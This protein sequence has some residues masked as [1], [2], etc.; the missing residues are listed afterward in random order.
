MTDG[1]YEQE[2]QNIYTT[3]VNFK[4]KLLKFVSK[5]DKIEKII[6]EDNQLVEDMCKESRGII[7]STGEVFLSDEMIQNFRLRLLAMCQTE[8]K[9]W[10]GYFLSIDLF[11]HKMI[12]FKT[13]TR[14]DN[15]QIYT[16][17]KCWNGKLYQ[18]LIQ[19]EALS[20]FSE[21]MFSKKTND[22]VK[23]LT[24]KLLQETSE[25]DARYVKKLKNKYKEGKQPHKSIEKSPEKDEE[26]PS[27]QNEFVETRTLPDEIPSD[28]EEKSESPGKIEDF[29]PGKIEDFSPGKTEDF[30]PG[31]TEDFSPGKIEDISP[32]TQKKNPKIVYTEKIKELKEIQPIKIKESSLGKTEDFSPKNVSDEEIENLSINKKQNTQQS[33][34]I[35]PFETKKHPDE[36]LI[37]KEEETSEISKQSDD[38][39]K[40]VDLKDN[41]EKEVITSED[42]IKPQTKNQ[43][44]EENIDMKVKDEHGINKNDENE[45]RT[46]G[47]EETTVRDKENSNIQKKTKK[48]KKTKHSVAKRN[49][50]NNDRSNVTQVNDSNLDDNEMFYHIKKD[51]KIFYDTSLTEDLDKKYK[52]DDDETIDYIT[53]DE[54][55]Y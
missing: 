5:F 6:I 9:V 24:E 34:E 37:T 16:L 19:A 14:E 25:N 18:N 4:K 30:S 8:F 1:C 54:D 53:S 15:E 31:K 23:I 52:T 48:T 41:E 2:L 17:W 38:S 29:S 3:V 50:D 49:M 7:M 11:L 39:D 13:I 20:K 32:K 43:D 33:K 22:I 45:D 47:D 27:T 21:D 35:I 42:K 36:K 51:D 55:F 12:S 46:S 28:E 44:G 26:T 10:Y 40:H